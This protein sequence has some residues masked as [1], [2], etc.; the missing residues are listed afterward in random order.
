MN[1]FAQEYEILFE[2]RFL[3]IR[4]TPDG[5]TFV[6]EIR[7]E[8]QIVV[9]LPFRYKM[10][11]SGVEF[12]ARRE[13]CPAHSREAELY[14]ITGGKEADLS[15]E[16]TACRELLEESGLTAMQDELIPLG[17]VKPSKAMD[18]QVSL[19]AV[20][21]TGKKQV[22]P[23]VDGSYFEQGSSVEWVSS[24][25]GVSIEDPLLVT[26]LTRLRTRQNL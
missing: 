3:Q 2:N 9:L 15:L 17:I 6:H 21:V 8:G 23:Q 5:Y 16:A 4:Q 12:L 7:C 22:A 25:E 11:M 14:S 18:T 13:V 10:D 20:D 24:E 26:A 19:F 1:Q